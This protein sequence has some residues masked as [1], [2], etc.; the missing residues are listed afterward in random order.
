MAENKNGFNNLLNNVKKG[1]EQID[2]DSLKNSASKVADA[3]IDKA[4]VAKDKAIALKDDI[5]DKLTELDRMLEESVTNYNDAYTSMSDKGLQLYIE[6]TRS[7]DTIDFVESIVNSIAN[8]P[9]SF[10]SE[11]EEIEVNKKEFTNSCDFAEREIKNARE[12]AVGAGVGLAAGST[13]AFM[14]PTAAMWVATT[15]GTASTGTAIATLTGAAAQNAALAWLGGGALAAGG[16]G[17]SAGSAFLALSGPVGCS[18]AGASLLATIVL[19]TVKK[20]K[21]NKEKKEEILKVKEN[22]EKVKEINGEIS[23]IITETVNIRTELNRM[24]K[25]G[26]KLYGSDYLTLSDENKQYL[27]ALVNNTKSL[28]ALFGRTI[29]Q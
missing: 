2:V 14:A 9:K 7:V 13:V 28:S 29:S 25:S 26:F 21:N 4:A 10:S 18:I 6:R 22:T 15:F 27:G 16:G 1:I 12:A 11:F 5:N 8:K 17:M 3:V 23:K 24:V 19:F 20:N